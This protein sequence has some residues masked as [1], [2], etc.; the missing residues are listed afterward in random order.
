MQTSN[1]H[2]ESGDSTPTLDE[3]AVNPSIVVPFDLDAEKR[4]FGGRI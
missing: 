3:A 4:V 2:N 1:L